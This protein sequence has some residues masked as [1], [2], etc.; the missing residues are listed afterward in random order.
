MNFW[1][2]LFGTTPADSSNDKTRPGSGSGAASNV[3]QPMTQGTR[4]TAVRSEE[5][6]NEAANID[7]TPIMFGATR[8]LPPLESITTKPGKHMVYGVN[9][10]IG[11]IRNNNQ[12]SLYTFFG[13]SVSVETMPDF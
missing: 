5:E 1:R 13:N 2:R 6:I 10:D 3:A 12:D 7:A 4:P 9:S 8:Q 11:M